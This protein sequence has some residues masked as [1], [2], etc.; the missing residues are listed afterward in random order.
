MTIVLSDPVQ[1]EAYHLHALRVA[2]FL[3][4]SGM[5]NSRESAY[6]KIKK[7]YGFKGNRVSVL[8][9]LEDF[10]EGQ[11]ISIKRRYTQK[12]GA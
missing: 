10:M 4:V 5:A 6:A 8:R 7:T 2:L 11:D 9:Q 1:I 3:E 12:E